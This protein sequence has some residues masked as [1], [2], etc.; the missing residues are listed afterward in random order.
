VY[1]EYPEL[2]N[3]RGSGYRWLS[4]FHAENLRIFTT[5]QHEPLRTTK[6]E[7]VVLVWFV[8]NFQIRP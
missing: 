5:N 3:I 7:F 1:H 6:F 2:K 8:V 4:P